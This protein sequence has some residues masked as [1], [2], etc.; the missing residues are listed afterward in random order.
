MEPGTNAMT[1]PP[2]APAPESI[3]PGTNAVT[4][5]PPAAPE[6]IEPGTTMTPLVSLLHDVAA[7]YRPSPSSP[8]DVGPLEATTG[9]SAVGVTSSVKLSLSQRDDLI[10]ATIMPPQTL[11]DSVT[12]TRGCHCLVI[13][14]SFSSALL[15][16]HSTTGDGAASCCGCEALPF[17]ILH[18]RQT[19]D[20]L[21]PARSGDVSNDHN[22]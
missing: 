16:T 22:R 14:V 20:C 11:A 2:P 3:E 19:N 8:E 9:G 17:P 12:A 5:P 13:D 6:S 7:H 15:A 10:L 18:A 1:P 4:P 21:P